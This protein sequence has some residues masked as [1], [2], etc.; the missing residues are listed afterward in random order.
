VN[1]N[2]RK[3]IIQKRTLGRTSFETSEISL[4][5]WQIGGKAYGL[6]PKEQAFAVI[7][8]YLELGGNFIDTAV[9][10]GDSEALLGEYFVLHGGREQV[11]IASKTPILDAKDIRSAVEGSLR[12]LNTDYID[13][14]YLHAPP[15][16]PGEMHRVL[17]VF[18]TLKSEGMIRAIGASIKG[19]NVTPHTLDLCRQYIRSNRVDVLMIILSIFRQ[20]NAEILPEAMENNVG[21]VARTALESGFLTGK[22]LPGHEFSPDD[23]RRR[24]YGDHLRAILDEVARF[25]NLALATPFESLTQVAIRFA[26]D[27]EG[28]SNL[29]LGA[30][31][32][33]QVKSNIQAAALPPL[34]PDLT[35]EFMSRYRGRTTEFNTGG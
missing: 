1:L 21:I 27:Q 19:P 17:D 28:V 32:P 24:W 2:W 35:Q 22:F 15:D 6:V 14:Y 18:E 10:Y 20:M 3:T 5:A 26:L 7:K 4:G 12:L 16:D 31:T 11:Y 33:E 34:L 30:R 13:I 8:T 25:K 9:G 29:V 23:H